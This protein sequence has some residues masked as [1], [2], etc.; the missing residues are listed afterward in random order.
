[1][2]KEMQR[3]AQAT[4]LNSPPLCFLKHTKLGQKYRGYML[5]AL[6]RKSSHASYLKGFAELHHS[7]SK[8]LSVIKY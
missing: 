5:T 6:R 3:A 8:S 7:Y 2:E 4:E 1:M